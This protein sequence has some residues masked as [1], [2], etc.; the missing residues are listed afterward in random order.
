VRRFASLR[1][2]FMLVAIL[3]GF[4]APTLGPSARALAQMQGIPTDSY[5]GMPLGWAELQL[6]EGEREHVWRYRL[7][8]PAE[9]EGDI[10][11]CD[12]IR[13]AVVGDDVIRWHANKFHGV[14]SGR[15]PLELMVSIDGPEGRC[16]LY[17][18]QVAMSSEEPTN[19]DVDDPVEVGGKQGT[20][21]SRYRRLFPNGVIARRMDVQLLRERDNLYLTGGENVEWQTRNMEC[22]L[23][24]V[25]TRRFNR[26]VMYAEVT[27]DVSASFF[28]D[29]AY[30]NTFEGGAPIAHGNT[31]DPG[32]LEL[33]NSLMGM[34][35][36][37]AQAMGDAADTSLPDE[38]MVCD[39]NGENCEEL[40]QPPPRSFEEELR[41][42]A[43]EDE[44]AGE[45][46]PAGY[47]DSF[48]LTMSDVKFSTRAIDTY[49]MNPNWTD[50]PDEAVAAD[51]LGLVGAFSLAASSPWNASFEGVELGE[52]G[53]SIPLST[54]Y[55]LPGAFDANFSGVKFMWE[56]GGPGEAQ[57]LLYGLEENRIAGVVTGAL[58]SERQYQDGYLHITVAAGFV[59]LRGANSC[60]G[61]Y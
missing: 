7:R 8:P 9:C 19:Q 5:N 47:G 36:A 13:Q 29:V 55:V 58:Q 30:F 44:A 34:A 27:G 10:S 12:F 28:G 31:F 26:C 16:P 51:Q 20:F 14:I 37:G 33:L 40:P 53:M 23:T 3:F 2:V 46:M 38:Q 59:A 42:W 50:R 61:Q 39:E 4:A 18:M 22:E 32:T 57:L 48:G 54:M 35:T 1:P 21:G 43:A 45:E 24:I 25:L 6:P 52:A 49:Y 41:A 60:Q 15:G 56:Q 11:S 17:A